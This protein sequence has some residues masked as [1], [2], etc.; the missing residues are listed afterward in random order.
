MEWMDGW[1]GASLDSGGGGPGGWIKQ[2]EKKKEEMAMA[3]HISVIIRSYIDLR[4][5]EFSVL[6]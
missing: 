3:L 2:E 5:C 4:S 6:I 1:M